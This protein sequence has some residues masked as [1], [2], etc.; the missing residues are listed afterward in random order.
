MC[1][2][3]IL[4]IAQDAQDAIERRREGRTGMEEARF[5]IEGLAGPGLIDYVARRIESRLADVSPIGQDAFLLLSCAIC[6]QVPVR[7]EHQACARPSELQLRRPG[8]SAAPKKGI[9]RHGN[10]QIGFRERSNVVSGAG[11]CVRATS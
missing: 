8:S 11:Q 6:G 4:G 1:C 7:L 5:L 2:D 10:P 9:A 3:G